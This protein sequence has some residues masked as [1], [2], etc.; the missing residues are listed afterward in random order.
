M[1]VN[2]K[3]DIYISLQRPTPQFKRLDALFTPLGSRI[4]V[5]VTPCGFRVGRIWVGFLGV[6][7][8]SLAINFISPFIHTHLIYLVSFHF[9]RPS[10]G[11]SGVVGR[12]PYYSHTVTSIEGASSHFI[13]RSSHVLDKICG[14]LIFAE[15]N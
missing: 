12:S 3:S 6:F 4:R 11:A 14:Y 9:I 13:S 1:Q 15:A 2:L 10:D 5:S 7:P 8:F